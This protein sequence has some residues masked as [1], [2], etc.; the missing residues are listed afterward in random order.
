MVFKRFRNLIEPPSPAA[1]PSHGARRRAT[2]HQKP[3]ASEG[4]FAGI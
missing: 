1:R 3:P 4:D 2:L